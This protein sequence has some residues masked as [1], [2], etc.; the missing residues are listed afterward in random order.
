[1]FRFLSC[2]CHNEIG[3][4]FMFKIL[5][6]EDDYSYREYLSAV[7]KQASYQVF[8]AKNGQ[9]ALLKLEQEK[10]SLIVLD[11]MM[12]VMDGF[13]FLKTIRKN[14]IDIP[15][16]I[17][18]AK[19]LPQ[20]KREAF[21]LGTDDYLIKPIDE[22]EMLLRIKALLR[23]AKIESEKKIVFPHTIVDYSSL[24]IRTDD[25]IITLPK[26]EFLLLYKLLS[27]LD[28]AFTRYQLM[29]EIWGYDNESND[30]TVAVHINRLRN[31]LKNIKDFEIQ[32][33]WGIGYKA[34]RKK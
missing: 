3:V 32:T 13:E 24:E 31:K 19:H 22:E 30:V 28:V 14:D 1:M 7:L 10:I 6:V 26:K 29:D 11:V 23:R 4:L 27:N 15:V 9:E 25:K 34:V 21:I 5:V 12:P 33:I 20:D 8:M 2:L 17:I 16:L 18:T